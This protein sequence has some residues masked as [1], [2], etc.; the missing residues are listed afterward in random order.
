MKTTDSRAACRKFR[1]Y[2]PLQIRPSAMTAR[3]GAPLRAATLAPH[4]AV[5]TWLAANITPASTTL[6]ER[7]LRAHEARC[8]VNMFIVK[9][10]DDGSIFQGPDVY[11]LTLEIQL[12]GMRPSPLMRLGRFVGSSDD[13]DAPLWTRLL[14]PRQSY[15]LTEPRTFAATLACGM[16]DIEVQSVSTED[17]SPRMRAWACTASL[18]TYID[19]AVVRHCIHIA[20]RENPV[21]NDNVTN[22][23]VPRRR[24]VRRASPVKPG[25]RRNNAAG[26]IPVLRTRPLIKRVVKCEFPG[27]ENVDPHTLQ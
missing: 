22:E 27:K 14:K 16:T 25:L 17:I 3:Y 12:Q 20:F 23:V 24:L 15:Y 13:G 9:A 8:I 19:E 6:P 7:P 5:N 4:K 11:C 2:S 1:S 26:L 18:G 21:I 10:K